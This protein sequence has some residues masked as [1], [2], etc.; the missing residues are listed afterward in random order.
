M[1]QRNNFSVVIKKYRGLKLNI[2]FGRHSLVGSVLGFWTRARGS[3]SSS[4]KAHVI[5]DSFQPI[6]IQYHY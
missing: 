2:C 4:F 5:L 3:L 6:V 1:E